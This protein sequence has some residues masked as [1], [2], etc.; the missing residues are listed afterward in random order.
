MNRDTLHS[1]IDRI[2]EREITAA[3]LFLQYLAA[4]PAYRSA[5]SAPPDD[6]PVTPADRQ[7]FQ[8]ANDDV[9][10]GRL[11]SHEEVLREFGLE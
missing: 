5:M 11:V 3:G 9:Q 10:A 6:E 7:A 2:P 1:L 8:R 4:H